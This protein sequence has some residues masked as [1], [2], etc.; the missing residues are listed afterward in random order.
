MQKLDSQRGEGAYFQGMVHILKEYQ[1]SGNRYFNK[2][3]ER[4]PA[5][6]HFSKKWHPSSKRL[7]YLTSVSSD[8]MEAAR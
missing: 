6:S 2:C 4:I 3:C 8:K 5:I 1:K 7:E